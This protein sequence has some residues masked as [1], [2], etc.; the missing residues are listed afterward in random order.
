LKPQQT[1]IHQ[2]RWTSF[3]PQNI[4][5]TRLDFLPLAIGTKKPC[6]SHRKAFSPLPDSVSGFFTWKKCPLGLFTAAA[7]PGFSFA[8]A[9]ASTFLNG[10][11]TGRACAAGFAGAFCFC[12]GTSL[13]SF[14][15][16]F[17]GAAN[18]FC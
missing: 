4:P 3:K 9:N 13:D 11:S 18:F 1:E 16:S 6:D 17:F 7:L 5:G 10:Y 2:N 12:L 8:A 14:C 15:G